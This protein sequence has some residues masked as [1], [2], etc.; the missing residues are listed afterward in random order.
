M[1]RVPL[2]GDLA[3]VNGEGLEGLEHNFITA[4]IETLLSGLARV[5]VGRRLL[6]W[7]V[8]RLK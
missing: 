3:K 6:V 7:H 2:I 5:V 4:R 8:V 1:A